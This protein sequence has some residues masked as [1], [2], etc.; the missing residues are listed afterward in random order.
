MGFRLLVWLQDTGGSPGARVRSSKVE[1]R[2]QDYLGLVFEGL[3]VQGFMSRAHPNW[4]EK[5]VGG[6]V[7]HNKDSSKLDVCWGPLIY[8]DNYLRCLDQER[9]G[10]KPGAKHCKVSRF[11]SSDSGIPSIP[12]L[13]I[14]D[15]RQPFGTI[16]PQPTEAQFRLRRWQSP[17]SQLLALNRS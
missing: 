8:G 6:G 11:Y 1:G 4:V 15:F 12:G 17:D 2:V 3:A 5:D 13:G 14:W 7:P 10:E 9:F 16:N